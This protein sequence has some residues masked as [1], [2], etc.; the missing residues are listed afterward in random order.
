MIKSKAEIPISRTKSGFLKFGSSNWTRTSDIRINSPPFY[1]LNYG[2]IASF[3]RT[4]R[5]LAMNFESVNAKILFPYRLLT[6]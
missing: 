6:L 1:R 3:L 2:G 5:I 4:R